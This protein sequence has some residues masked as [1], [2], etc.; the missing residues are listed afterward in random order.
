MRKPPGTY[1]DGGGLYLQ[2]S[3][4]L[5]RSW[6]FRF[7]SLVRGKE[8]YMGLGPI[9]TI[10]LA[11]ARELANQARGLVASGIDPI[12]E[13]KVS[14]QTEKQK[15][16][17]TFE[18]AVEGFIAANRHGWTN[19]KSEGQWR[20]SLKMYAY[21]I[22]GKLP[23]KT[24]AEDDVLKILEPIWHDKKETAS[25]VRGRIERILDRE[26]ALKHR[27][28]ENPARLIWLNTALGKQ[29]HQIHHFKAIPYTAIAS[30]MRELK[31]AEGLGAMALQFTILTLARTSEALNARLDEFDLDNGVWTIPAERMKAR[32]EHRVPLSQPAIDIVMS[33]QQ[34]QIS[35]Y[36]FPSPIGNKPLS[37]NAM[38]ATIKRMGRKGEFTVH[39]MRSAFRD[40]A[41]EQT[42]V[43]REVAEAALA[44]TISD[45]V[46]RAY[47]RGDLF[48]KRSALMDEWASY[49]SSQEV[50]RKI[51]Q[52]I[53]SS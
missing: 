35:D 51:V 13:R 31:E 24:I 48:E 4:N 3:E 8:R 42:D 7:K 6:I 22:I 39:G 28:G 33:F 9:H 16:S 45:A 50:G 27:S 12:D 47:R 20:S 46:E 29:S 44:H 19:T 36:L 5:S 38:L 26:T 11:Q 1:L 43:S 17:M 34:H 30:F 32:K 25:R 49:C 2:V 15:A 23:V 18:N 21:P 14:R 53:Q 40:W 37:N 41:A 52:L 10:S